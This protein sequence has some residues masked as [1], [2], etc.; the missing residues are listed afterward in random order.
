MTMCLKQHDENNKILEE[1]QIKRRYIK[2]ICIRAFIVFSCIIGTLMSI[3]TFFDISRLAERTGV[4]PKFFLTYKHDQI[5]T[6]F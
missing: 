5:S 3:I 6:T 4:E 2:T 1:M